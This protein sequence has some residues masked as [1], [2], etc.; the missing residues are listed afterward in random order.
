MSAEVGNQG[1][2]SGRGMSKAGR[3][4]EQ[5]GRW[6]NT[7]RTRQ[8]KVS[9]GVGGQANKVGR[10]SKHESQSTWLDC[11]LSFLINLVEG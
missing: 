8:E 9:V 7:G 3:A 5:V 4:S 11:P 6:E 10:A 1:A 2:V